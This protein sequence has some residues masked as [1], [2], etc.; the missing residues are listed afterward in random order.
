MANKFAIL[1]H[2]PTQK[3]LA[4]SSYYVAHGSPTAAQGAPVP[5]QIGN[6][7]HCGVGHNPVPVYVRQI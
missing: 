4:A 2:D 5:F 7:V 1:G 6:C 3:K